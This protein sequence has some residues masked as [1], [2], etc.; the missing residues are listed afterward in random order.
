MVDKGNINQFFNENSDDE[1]IDNDDN[2]LLADELLLGE[3]EPEDVKPKRP[4]NF[5]VLG[6]GSSVLGRGSSALGG[7]SSVLGGGSSALGSGR[8]SEFNL[9]GK[10]KLA[11]GQI[12]FTKLGKSGLRESTD[13]D[14]D[15]V[16]I[17]EEFSRLGIESE[18]QSKKVGIRGQK[19]LQET[20]LFE[21]PKAA[22][23]ETNQPSSFGGSLQSLGGPMSFGG[24]TSLGGSTSTFG[25]GAAT[26]GRGRGRSS[27]SK[28]SLRDSD[29]GGVYNTGGIVSKQNANSI[30]DL[31]EK[32]ANPKTLNIPAPASTDQ[33]SDE[34][35]TFIIKQVELMDKLIKV[36]GGIGD[37][38]R[39]IPTISS[40]KGAGVEEIQDHLNILIKQLDGI[41]ESNNKAYLIIPGENIDT[42]VTDKHV[43]D[44]IQDR[45]VSIVGSIKDLSS[46]LTETEE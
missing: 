16:P 37:K 23:R 31:A 9:P 13:F 18:H 22:K 17:D 19:T 35:K 14:D 33:S 8:T 3:S 24:S 11:K 25:R 5:G 32:R 44:L 12:K 43:L 15:D 21:E 39:E 40:Y 34:M 1:S 7:G 42:N 45:H 29:L 38:F 6:G 4:S 30:L 2:A 36:V 10:N 27:P 41:I 46:V 28:P 20:K 26:R